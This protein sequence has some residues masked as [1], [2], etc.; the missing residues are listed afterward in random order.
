[1]VGSAA[2][3]S[4]SSAFSLVAPPDCPLLGL[5]RLAR[6]F[7]SP[8][9]SPPDLAAFCIDSGPD[10][11]EAKFLVRAIL[12]GSVVRSDGRGLDVERLLR[13]PVIVSNRSGLMASG[14]EELRGR[15]ELSAVVGRRSL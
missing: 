8:V 3:V 11:L 12:G 10:L 9:L 13:T 4:F 2:F 7:V 14:R 5:A 6:A 1:M 15:G